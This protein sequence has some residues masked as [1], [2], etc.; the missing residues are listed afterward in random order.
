MDEKK[1]SRH[2]LNE[3]ETWVFD[4]DNTLY[5]AS[6]DLFS[7]IDVRMKGF[8][9]E[10]LGLEPHEAFRVQKRYF[11]EYGTTLRGLMIRHDMEPLDFLRHV[12]AIDVSCVPPNPKLAEVLDL[13]PG[14]KVVFTNASKDHAHR[15]M[16]RL[17]V[18]QRFDG[19]FDIISADYLPKPEP[20]VYRAL[21]E[22]F[23]LE[24]ERTVMFEDMARNLKP[25]ADL[26]MTTVWVRT[27][28]DWGRDGAHEDYVHHIAD[29]LASWLEGVLGKVGV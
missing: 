25:A 5:P 2:R 11:R 6:C 9:A 22:H 3:T 29:D 19:V 26:G 21:I 28:N 16:A 7:Q 17:G 18:A 10:F 13:L 12:H 14:R 8:I 20:G 15:V 24:P 23:G 4:L 27:E 1:S